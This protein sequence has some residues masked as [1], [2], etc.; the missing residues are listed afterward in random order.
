[1]ALKEILNSILPTLT[2]AQIA[3]ETLDTN[4]TG[5]DDDAAKQVSGLRS[6]IAGY[7]NSLPQD[8]AA[9]GY[10]QIK[11]F[12]DN[13]LNSLEIII[14]SDLPKTEKVKQAQSLVNDLTDDTKVFP[15]RKGKD[16]AYLQAAIRTAHEK[17]TILKNS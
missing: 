11:A 6:A 13:V 5:F 12:C 7:L 17:L 15:A 2:I 10:V 3:L 4:T 16:G 1:M 14:E 8:T 9:R